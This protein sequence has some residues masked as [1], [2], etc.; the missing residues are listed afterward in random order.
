MTSK[1]KQNMEK[2]LSKIA[3]SDK[4][5]IDFREM[6]NEI[7]EQRS[8]DSNANYQKTPPSPKEFIGHSLLQKRIESAITIIER[9]LE[10]PSWT[11]REKSFMP[12]TLG[13]HAEEE[14]KRYYTSLQKIYKDRVVEVDAWI[15]HAVID[16]L[17]FL[18][19]ELA[20][21]KTYEVLCRS[22][23]FPFDQKLSE[24]HDQ[25]RAAPDK[26]EAYQRAAKKMGW[27]SEKKQ[28]D[29]KLLFEYLDLIGII[30]T[31]YGD[32]L[33]EIDALHREVYG[34]KQPMDRIEAIELLAAKYP[35]PKRGKSNKQP[36]TNIYKRIQNA[37]KKLKA[38]LKADGRPYKHL[39]KILP[40]YQEINVRDDEAR[41]AYG[42]EDPEYDE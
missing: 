6:M 9:V 11:Q 29:Y 24:I 34:E 38:A 32:S 5:A 17:R 26:R 18:N 7:N 31:K 25:I 28:P 33:P 23:Y 21:A 16:C 2:I 37:K 12:A 22:V 20:W 15:L 1:K 42:Y 10:R 19:E 40:N 13:E 30:C 35:D 39:D 14:T 8:V 41:D 36:R 3:D 4:F 27:T